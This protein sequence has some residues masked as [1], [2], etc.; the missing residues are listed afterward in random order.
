MYWRWNFVVLVLAAMFMFVAAA[1]LEGNL[2]RVDIIAT[3]VGETSP[4]L[5]KSSPETLVTT[6]NEQQSYR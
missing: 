1:P 6:L 2:A 5:P 3:V 4:Q